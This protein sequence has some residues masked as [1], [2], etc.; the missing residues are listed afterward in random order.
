MVVT[1]IL[2]CVI[3]LAMMAGCTSTALSAD[4]LPPAVRTSCQCRDG[5]W[6]WVTEAVPPPYAVVPNGVPETPRRM[7]AEELAEVL[8]GREPFDGLRFRLEEP[9]SRTLSATRPPSTESALEDEPRARTDG[10]R[11][12]LAMRDGR[13]IDLFGR[14]IRVAADG[15][16][17]DA[18]LFDAAALRLEG[19][20]VR[21][22]DPARAGGLPQ[23]AT[24]IESAAADSRPLAGNPATGRT[25]HSADNWMSGRAGDNWLSRGVNS[26]LGGGEVTDPRVAFGPAADSPGVSSPDRRTADPERSTDRASGDTTQGTNSRSTRTWSV[27][28]GSPGGASPSIQSGVPGAGSFPPPSPA[29]SLSGGA[30]GGTPGIPRL[31]TNSFGGSGGD[32]LQ[33]TG[34]AGGGGGGGGGGNAPAEPANDPPASDPSAPAAPLPAVPQLARA[35]DPPAAVPSVVAADAPAAV[36]SVLA[37]DPSAAMHSA[38]AVEPPVDRPSVP[39]A[40]PA[41]DLFLEAPIGTPAVP[42]SDSALSPLIVC[43]P[44]I[45]V[46]EIPPIAPKAPDEECELVSEVPVARAP[47][48]TPVVPEPGSL[49]LLALGGGFGGAVWLRRR[50]KTVVS[51]SV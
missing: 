39:L 3:G 19:P 35:V 48:Q 7:S 34:G 20:A 24:G 31:S 50:R 49:I 27:M 40:E 47:G 10:E 37:A 36:P 1:R 8:R 29:L 22:D 21:T 18:R 26:R 41:A 46:A 28:P 12:R 38:L 32:G 17:A 42:P 15:T 45:P 51:P 43:Q 33:N 23:T 44:E 13:L 25:S 2:S 9:L 14:P 6:Q 30:G 4:A 16:V 5:I 11:T